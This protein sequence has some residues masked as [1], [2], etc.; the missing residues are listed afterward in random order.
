MTD[1]AYLTLNQTS[2]VGV[3]LGTV[4]SVREDWIGT[5][6]TGRAAERVNY[7]V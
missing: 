2:D 6:G 1:V 3:L 4:L 7:S 5:V